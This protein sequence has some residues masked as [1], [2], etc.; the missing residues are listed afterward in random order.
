LCK[1][2][3]VGDGRLDEVGDLLVPVLEVHVEALFCDVDFSIGKPLV[4]VEVIDPEDGFGEGVPVDPFCFF[5]PVGEGVLEGAVE[6]C[7]V[8]EAKFG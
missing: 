4:E 8:G 5:A 6:C 2:Y 3:R 7:L 1:I